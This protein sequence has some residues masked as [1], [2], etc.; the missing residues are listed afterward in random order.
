ML[1]SDQVLDYWSSGVMEYWNPT[2]A[3]HNSIIQ[4]LPL[5]LTPPLHCSFTSHFSPFRFSFA[6]PLGVSSFGAKS[7][8]PSQRWH[9]EIGEQVGRPPICASSDVHHD[10]EIRI[11]RWRDSWNLRR[12][13]EKQGET[14]LAI[15]LEHACRIDE[16]ATFL[17]I[18]A[19]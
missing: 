17:A 8:V 16:L 10:I 9:A 7:F 4:L 18:E 19:A 14:P 2:P 13:T 6:V 12:T 11:P 15:E 1:G 5:S 3:F